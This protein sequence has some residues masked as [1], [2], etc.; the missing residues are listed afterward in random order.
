MNWVSCVMSRQKSGLSARGWQLARRKDS[1]VKDVYFKHLNLLMIIHLFEYP[2]E[3]WVVKRSSPKK[4]EVLE[5]PDCWRSAMENIHCSRLMLFELPLTCQTE[6]D[7][8]HPGPHVQGWG[9]VSSLVLPMNELSVS[10]DIPLNG[11][12]AHKSSHVCYLEFLLRLKTKLGERW[13]NKKMTAFLLQ[14]VSDIC[15]LPSVFSA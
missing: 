10:K 12:I 3:R 1:G 11:K 14:N 9:R 4:L 6:I 7:Q 8:D 5:L 15:F 13:S 2:V